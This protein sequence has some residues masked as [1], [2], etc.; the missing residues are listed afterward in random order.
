MMNSDV[1]PR[2]MRGGLPIRALALL[3]GVCAIWAGNAVFLRYSIGIRSLPP[4]HVA[5]GRFLIV[6]VLLSPLLLR[7]ITNLPRILVAGLLMGACH[8]GFLMVGYGHITA[9]SSAVLLQ[10]GIPL[11]ALLSMALGAE[12]LSVRRLLLVVGST[13]AI[14]FALGGPGQLDLIGASCI[15]LAAA[16]LSLGSVIMARSGSVGALTIQ[17]WTSI[18]S[19]VVLSALAPLLEPEGLGELTAQ[20][21]LAAI[22]IV[23]PALIV[24]VG[25]HTVYYHLLKNHPP[26]LVSAVTVLFPV[27]TI[28]FGVVF[29]SET[30]RAQFVIG[31][32]IAVL[33]LSLLVIDRRR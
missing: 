31:T 20:P 15:I 18:G 24:T 23:A 21:W 1:H 12:R 7:P 30:L 17:A 13:V 25:A 16:T 19:A 22:S 8:F 2:E 9:V 4:I 6:A 14:I 10:I 28:V 5:A 32:T 26:S 11:T 27:L 33:I 29:L 3:I